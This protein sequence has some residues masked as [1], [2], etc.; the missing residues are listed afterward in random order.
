M[1]VYVRNSSRILW[2]KLDKYY[3]YLHG[4]YFYYYDA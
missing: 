2:N 3:S 1:N 4:Q